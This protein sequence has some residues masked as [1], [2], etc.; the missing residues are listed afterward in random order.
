MAKKSNDTFGFAIAAV[1]TEQFFANP[2]QYS[3]DSEVQLTFGFNFKLSAKEEMIGVF[4]HLSYH[5]GERALIN[6][7]VGCHFKIEPSSWKEISDETNQK[8]VLPQAVALHLCT[9]ATGTARGILHAKLSGSP[10]AH[11]VLPAVNLTNVIKED[12][13]LM[14]NSIDS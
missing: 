10:F 5:Q 2:S 9:I 6:L 13:E 4:M 12:V 8:L 11:Y 14:M 3:T 1:S 7:E